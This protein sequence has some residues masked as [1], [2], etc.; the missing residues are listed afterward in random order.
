MLGG[1]EC[2]PHARLEARWS[3]VDYTEAFF[4]CDA[5]GADR[6]LLEEAADE[7]DSVWDAAWLL[8]GRNRVVWIRRPVAAGF[9]LHETGAQ[10]K[11]RM[12]GEVGDGQHLVAQR[13]H[14]Q[15]V[16]LRKQFLHFL[17]DFAAH[18]V[19]LHEVNR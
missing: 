19:G 14:Q 4:Q 6:A 8:E 12:A 5:D 11:R 15:E 3:L 1:Q 7:G 17:R 2:P 18:P 9:L 13:G 10:G 16:H